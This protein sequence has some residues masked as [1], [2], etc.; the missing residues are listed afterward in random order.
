MPF[1]SL[2]YSI[3]FITFLQGEEAPG[4]MQRRVTA[5]SIFRNLQSTFCYLI[6]ARIRLYCRLW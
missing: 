3:N 5:R 1:I 6:R 2:A 4:L